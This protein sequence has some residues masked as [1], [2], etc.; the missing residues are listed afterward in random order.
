MNQCACHLGSLCAPPQIHS[1]DMCTH[2]FDSTLVMQIPHQTAWKPVIPNP[3]ETSFKMNTTLFQKL[4]FSII[5]TNLLVE[6]I[7]TSQTHQSGRPNGARPNSFY[8]VAKKR[9]FVAFG[10]RWLCK[11]SD[12]PPV[13]RLGYRPNARKRL[14]AT[15]VNDFGLAPLGRPLRSQI[16]TIVVK[17]SSPYRDNNSSPLKKTG[18]VYDDFCT[19]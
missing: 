13:V 8:A 7:E 12:G 11:C 6:I 2:T 18:F 15:A 5:R 1:H 17:C 14:L 10:R 19:R 3:L 16:K 9:R 4:L